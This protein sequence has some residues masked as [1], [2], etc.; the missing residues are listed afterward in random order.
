MCINIIGYNIATNNNI[1][2]VNNNFNNISNI[3]NMN[4]SYTTNDPLKQFG[5]GCISTD[6]SNI[7]D[8][9]KSNIQINTA[10]YERLQTPDLNNITSSS[11]VNFKGDEPIGLDLNKFISSTN[12]NTT[13]HNISTSEDLLIIQDVSFF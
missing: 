9:D 11:F 8:T 1:G 6:M 12:P 5:I 2:G 7:A 10:D 13:I 3:S 4:I